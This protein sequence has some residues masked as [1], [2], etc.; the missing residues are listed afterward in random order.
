MWGNDLE[1]TPFLVVNG[2]TVDILIH[3]S[4]RV[5][6]VIRENGTTPTFGTEVVILIFPSTTTLNTIPNH[7]RASV[8]NPAVNPVNHNHISFSH[9]QL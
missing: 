5:T 7:T 3:R 9:Y 4:T 2:V 1:P 6:S 8:N